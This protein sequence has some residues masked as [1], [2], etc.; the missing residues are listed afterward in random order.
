[1][2]AIFYKM[3]L[4]LDLTRKIPSATG[5]NGR[6]RKVAYLVLYSQVSGCLSEF[7]ERTGFPLV[8]LPRVVLRFPA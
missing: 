3:P 1:M 2:N 7:D 8:L 6:N 4:H 5:K